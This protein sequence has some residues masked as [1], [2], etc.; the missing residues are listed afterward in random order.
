[1]QRARLEFSGFEQA[2]EEY[3]EAR[4]VN[5]IESLMQDIRYG[6][7]MLRKS[8]GFVAVAVLTLALGIGA[9]MAIFSATYAI[10][11]KPLAYED[12]SRLVTI[13]AMPPRGSDGAE[14][15]IPAVEEI[16]SHITVFERVA[17][18]ELQDYRLT[19]YGSPELLTTGIVSGNY[20][21]T[22]GVRPVLGRP[23]IPADTGPESSHVAV[24]SYEFWQRHFG[25]DPGVLG[26]QIKLLDSSNNSSAPESYTV[27]GM[28]PPTF[29]SPGF[30]L[31][32]YDVWIPLVPKGHKNAEDLGGDN[33]TVARLKQGVTLD[34][35]N[36][37]LRSLSALLGEEY[38][39]T[40]KGWTL[41]AQNLQDM[42]VAES[43][44][45]LLILLGAVAFVLL[46]ACL[47]VSNLALARGWGRLREVAIRQALGATRLRVVFQ[48]LVESI[49]VSLFGGAMGL[50]LGYGGVNLL[51]AIAPAETPRLDELRMY[52]VV[53]WYALGVSLAAGILFG[54]AP[55]IQVSGRKLHATMNCSATA[56]LFVGETQRPKGLR[57]V[58][59][60]AEVALSFVLLVGSAL[61][62]RSFAK[63]TS[64]SLGLRTDHVLSMF[65]RLDPSTC[66]EGTQCNSAFDRMAD[67][68][69][70]LPGVQSASVANY[71]PLSGGGI[72]LE[73]ELEGQPLQI[74]GQG[75]TAK[76]VEVGP[77]YLV[78][79][80]IPLLR[81]REF[82]SADT[83][84]APLIAIANE[85][86]ARRYFSG[87]ALGKRIPYGMDSNKK[88]RWIYIVGL[89]RD[90]RDENPSREPGPELYRPFAQENVFPQAELIVR[91]AADPIG[92]APA[93]REQVWAVD[94]NAPI[95]SVTTMDQL[96]SQ[97]VADPRFRVLLLGSFGT[98]G[99]V[100]AAVGIYGVISCSV[101]QRT[102]EIGV[103]MAMGAQRPDILRLVVGHELLFSLAGIGIGA[104]G[105]LALTRV[106][107]TLLFE[108][109]PTDPLTFAG[110]TITFVLVALAASYVP[111][112]RAMRVDPMV[113]L[114]HE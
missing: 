111:A 89:A 18:I 32:K 2:K 113:A 52:P 88:P 105:A 46:I 14:L 51:R 31:L 4:G 85:A 73:F 29:R 30:G 26:K 48:L 41:L 104:A 109:T 112:R 79:M 38:P 42:I 33:F 80:G 43:R 106:L 96:A 60:V 68:V 53:F 56:P 98:L 16:G 34:Q 107:R 86:F 20:F 15:S 114:R 24:L 61:A 100:L 91:T 75:P 94:K 50:L 95:D 78:T 58:L 92:L 57:N 9:N 66:R 83:G 36:V 63:L 17:T 40:D 1:M 12:P 76:I 74:P 44:R 19:D 25:G 55:A 72:T 8:P 71:G 70:A 87:Q 5:L 101:S 23:I 22:L 35:A 47:N 90:A 84:N 62:I 49:L 11:L 67:Q 69:R 10:L 45:A 82:T 81:G 99:L 7:R 110:V 28:A 54:L 77:D 13:S 93:I 102:R 21:A 97:S 64:V 59:L 27:I 6:L 37:E 108:I 39:Q 3:R 103:R 65:I